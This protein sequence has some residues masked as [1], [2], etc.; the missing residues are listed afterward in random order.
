RGRY[1]TAA[2]DC[3]ACHTA[4]GGTPFAGGR[5]IETPF[6]IIYSPN[7]T[8]DRDTGI[9]A[10]SDDQFYRALHEGI[11]ADGTYL[12]PAF[13]YPWY[14]KITREDA[15]AIRA[16]LDTLPPTRNKRSENQLAWPLDNRE[17]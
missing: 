16:F 9:G 17:V 10:W 14:T 6:G 12:Y 13:P 5:P 7:I 1:L 8:P 15:D 11:A 3:Q 2:G 4:K